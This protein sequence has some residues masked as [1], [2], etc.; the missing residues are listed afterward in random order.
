MERVVMVLD[1]TSANGP[2]QDGTCPDRPVCPKNGFPKADGLLKEIES[3]QA[4]THFAWHSFHAQTA[5]A[6]R[7]QANPSFGWVMKLIR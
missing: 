2:V 6:L 7:A 3:A 1:S 5:K 4:S